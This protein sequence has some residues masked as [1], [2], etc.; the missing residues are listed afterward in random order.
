MSHDRSS[1]QKAVVITM[2]SALAIIWLGWDSGPSPHEVY[3][4]IV[5]YEGVQDYEH[6]LVTYSAGMTI[7]D[8]VNAAIKK[9]GLP[10][11]KES[12][13]APIIDR[14][15]VWTWR[16]V[17]QRLLEV[18]TTILHKAGLNGAAGK[19]ELWKSEHGF[20]NDSHNLRLDGE[21]SLWTSEVQPNDYIRVFDREALG[22]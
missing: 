13:M 9:R 15:L 12:E 4:L 6:H 1:W 20:S 10:S 7:R 21:H 8:A 19:I 2:L 5:P 3:V 18:S 14:H 22:R 11:L 16:G 17:C